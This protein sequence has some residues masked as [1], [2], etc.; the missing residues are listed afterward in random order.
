MNR[1]YF[2][3]AAIALIGVGLAVVSVVAPGAIPFS[4]LVL[5]SAAVPAAVLLTA[6]GRLECKVP[7]AALV[8]GGTVAIA[9]SVIGYAVVGGAVYFVVGDFAEWLLHNSDGFVD[10]ELI[11]TIRD[12]WMIFFAIDL[13]ILA[14][15]VEEFAKAVSGR[16]SRPFDRKSAF[17]AGIAAGVGFAVIENIAYA[18]GGFFDVSGWEVVVLVRMLGSAVHPVAAGLVGL[19][20]WELRNGG[21]RSSAVRLI[22]V[23]VGVHALWNGA[24]LAV[25]VVSAAFSGDT[26]PLES[27]LVAIAYAG[28]LG[29]IIAAGGWQALGRVAK[30]ELPAATAT[31]GDARAMSA[32]VV[33]ASTMLIPAIA[34]VFALGSG[35]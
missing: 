27:V 29:T 1:Y 22:G 12:P 30:D 21:A 25:F 16:L 28:A 13:V 34:V 19:G 4:G 20:W 6:V 7:V 32:W 23:G 5:A 31:P 24:V 14:P 2:S 9:M 10:D 3:A 8:A 33:I 18:T 35:A 26:T 11:R 15:L 17:I